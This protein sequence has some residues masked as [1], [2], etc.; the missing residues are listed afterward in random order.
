MDIL[1]IAFSLS[2]VIHF[3]LIERRVWQHSARR[4]LLRALI[5]AGGALSV[6]FAIGS[7]MNAMVVVLLGGAL[8]ALWAVSFLRNRSA[9]PKE[10]AVVMM[11]LLTG[12]GVFFVATNP[13]NYPNP[14]AGVWSVY[15]DQ[16]RSLEVQKSIPAVHRAMR[17][18]GERIHA[19]AELTAFHPAIFGLVVAAFLFQLPGRRQFIITLWWLIAVVT[20]TAWLP[21]ARERYVL[22]VIAPSVALIGG[23]AER[24]AEWLR[25]KALAHSA[26]ETPASSG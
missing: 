10:S 11:I 15:A 4:R 22:P 9:G 2:A 5:C 13:E 17:S 24:L 20:V 8:C 1:A 7:K 14:V 18:G 23:S 6:A 19:L 21:F 12:A 26:G 3:V 25:R 16:Q